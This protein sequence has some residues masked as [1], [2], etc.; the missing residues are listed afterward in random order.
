MCNGFFFFFWGGGGG[1]GSIGSVRFFF[2]GGGGGV[3]FDRFGRGTVCQNWNPEV[4]DQTRRSR[5]LHVEFA[6]N[7]RELVKEE[8]FEERAFEQTTPLK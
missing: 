8:V 3:R 2:W 7:N 4:F 1:L 6:L 5:I